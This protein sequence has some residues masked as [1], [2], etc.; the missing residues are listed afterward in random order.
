MRAAMMFVALLA[1]ALPLQVNAQGTLRVGM[2]DDPDVLDPARSGTFAGRIVFAAACDK[3]IDLDPSLAFVPQLATS[4]AWAPDGLSLT[5]TLRDG[6][7]FQ[8]GA[9]LDAEAVRANLDRYRAAPESVR[10]TELKSVETVEVV[11]PLTVRLSLAHPDAPL[12]AVLADRAGMMLSPR[13]LADGA[14]PELPVCAGPFRIV[15]RVA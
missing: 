5:L 6:V 7:R 15:R 2:Q 11:D 14:R 1:I 10:K 8:D 9:T 13:S 3:L 12:L 4:W